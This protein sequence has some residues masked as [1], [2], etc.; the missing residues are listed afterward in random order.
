MLLKNVRQILS[1][2][3]HFELADR[4]MCKHMFEAAIKLLSEQCR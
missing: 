4:Q 2:K 1:D 3:K